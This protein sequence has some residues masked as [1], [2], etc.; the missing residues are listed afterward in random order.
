M[1]PFGYAAIV[2]FVLSTL[3]IGIKAMGSSVNF[4]AIGL[5]GWALTP[6]VLMFA[7]LK[8]VSGKA[9]TIIVILLIV[10]V[11]AFGN[12]ALV[13]TMFIHPDAQG[14]LIFIVAPLGQWIVLLAASFPIY[15]W[16]RRGNA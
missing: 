11:G 4:G 6:Y 16:K 5:I 15:L 8:F 3:A 2:L 7:M 14:G 1:K 13:D 10:L 9:S 12:Y